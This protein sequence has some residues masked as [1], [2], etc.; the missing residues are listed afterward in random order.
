MEATFK[1]VKIGR[2]VWMAENLNVSTFRNGD[3]I[4]E[5]ETNEQWMKAGDKKE[6]AWCYYENDK[7]N[8]PKY[9]KLYNWYA[10]N[11]PRV[12]S[13]EGWH[14]SDQEE[15]K[16]LVDH[17]GGEEVAGGKLKETGMANWHSPNKGASNESEFS[18]LPGGFRLADNGVPGFPMV[19]GEFGLIG[20]GAT[21]WT[22]TSYHIETAVIWLM[23]SGYS[24]VHADTGYKRYGYSVRCVKD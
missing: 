14:I 15:W 5:A 8:G 4:P 12:L 9:G 24:Y 16:S 7:S 11:D 20:D 2:Q 1:T 3:I 19:A 22:A 13:P 23:D 10:V 18:A 6:A 17:L 21:F